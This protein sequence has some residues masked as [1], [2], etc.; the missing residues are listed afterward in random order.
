VIADPLR[1]VLLV[2]FM[3]AGKSSVGRALARRLQW[4]FVD[5]DEAIERQAGVDVRQIFAKD[6]EER[7]RALED[8]VARRLLE[9]ER[10][11]LASGGGWAGTPGRL[12]GLPAGTETVW[13][14]VTAECALRRVSDEPGRRPLLDVE[15][16]LREAEALLERR[17][18]HYAAARHA[19]DTSG[20]SVDD[21]SARILEILAGQYPEQ[22]PNER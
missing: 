10:V 1:R 12:S 6:G 22:V 14:Q 15:H 7:F 13:L 4:G 16:P 8:E 5:F 9:Q 21:V 11:V 18:P 3:G 2:G 19:V 17:I 20:S